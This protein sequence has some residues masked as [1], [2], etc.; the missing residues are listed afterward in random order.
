MRNFGYSNNLEY[1]NADDF[2][3]PDEK[4]LFL[5]I[6][7]KVIPHQK[8][9]EIDFNVPEN[10][11]Y[12]LLRNIKL[13]DVKE[14][15][16]Q[17]EASTREYSGLLYN[18]NNYNGKVGLHIQSNH[19]SYIFDLMQELYKHDKTAASALLEEYFTQ[20]VYCTDIVS[21]SDIFVKQVS[22][23]QNYLLKENLV[24]ENFHLNYEQLS[25]HFSSL[26]EDTA[27]EELLKLQ[28]KYGEPKDFPAYNDLDYTPM[29]LDGDYC[30][31]D[32][33]GARFYIV[34][35]ME[36]SQ[37]IY[38]INRDRRKL[39]IEF[40][41]WLTD[42]AYEHNQVY[43]LLKD[44]LLES[45]LI[46][47]IKD[48]KLIK[49]SVEMKIMNLLQT[50][51]VRELLDEGK[52]VDNIPD[53]SFTQL[54]ENY[55]R[56]KEFYKI[57]ERAILPLLNN[58]I[59]SNNKVTYT[60]FSYMSEQTE[61]KHENISDHTIENIVGTDKKGKKLSYIYTKPDFSKLNKLPVD[62]KNQIKEYLQ[63]L[64]ERDNSDNAKIL[65]HTI[66]S[67]LDNSPNNKLKR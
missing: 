41:D 7:H 26:D 57:E 43:F 31:Y 34:K 1:A 14:K 22:Q 66:N 39:N 4:K 33:S 16:T 37:K 56:Q 5:K 52:I 24:V 36:D 45:D 35:Q 65:A 67:Y 64:T 44:T 6:P 32:S 9:N 2:F 21:I 50:F 60:D 11:K 23:M 51:I 53:L 59:I 18:T 13:I 27:Y 19:G 25:K 55:T 15:L 29:I 49:S 20:S 30:M 46:A 12:P 10:G 3:S 58:L 28:E 54:L 47:E 8:I 42:F 38:M 62:F 17:A 63:K 40:N 61:I 48:G